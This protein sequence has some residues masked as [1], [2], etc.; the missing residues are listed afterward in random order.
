MAGA[1]SCPPWGTTWTEVTPVRRCA[2]LPCRVEI[3]EQFAQLWAAERPDLEEL[4]CAVSANGR[5]D[6]ADPRVLLDDLVLSITERSGE[7]SGPGALVKALCGSGVL[8]GDTQTYDSPENSLL[9]RVLERGCGI[10]LSVAVVVVLLGRRLGVDLEIIGL[11]GHVVA[12]DPLGGSVFDVFDGGRVL[13]APSVVALA[14]RYE[15]AWQ[16][17]PGGEVALDVRSV[18]DRWCRNLRSAYVRLGDDS[19]LERVLALELRRRPPPSDALGAATT[20]LV[21]RGAYLE[22]AGLLEEHA[23]PGP[24]GDALRSSAQRLRALLN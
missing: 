7:P 9:D 21:A 13:D 4:V 24:T 1:S 11:P 18:V 3:P 15:P 6:A 2:A 22:A 23:L 12:R 19:G 17:R 14:R 5:P 8:R 16:P 20:R 10:P